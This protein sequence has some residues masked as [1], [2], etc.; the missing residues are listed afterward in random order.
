MSDPFDTAAPLSDD[1]IARRA[2]R[3]LARLKAFYGHLVVYIAVNVMLHLINLMTTQRYWAIW[4]LLGWGLAVALQASATFD[5]PMRLL[6]PD[7]EERKLRAF[8]DDER[9]KAGLH[10][11]PLS[12]AAP[13]E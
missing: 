13:R 12:P 7:W 1:D 11:P 5:W 9:R 3:R 6:A 2:H 10:R 8:A 4:P